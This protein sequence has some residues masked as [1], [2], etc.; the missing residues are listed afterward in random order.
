MPDQGGER[1]G[2]QS[3]PAPDPGARVI[4]VGQ[5]RATDYQCQGD[6]VGRG[7]IQVRGGPGPRSHA[8]N[9]MQARHH[10]CH[11][12]SGSEPDRYRRRTAARSRSVLLLALEVFT[13]VR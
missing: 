4:D 13:G 5:D 2:D 3:D 10:R 7:E 11:P 9:D 6:R 8:D 12:W 1:M